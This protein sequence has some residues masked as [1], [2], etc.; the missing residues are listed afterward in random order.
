MLFDGCNMLIAP[1]R[2]AR[3]RN[4]CRPRWNDDVSLRMPIRHS[5]VNSL[6]IIRA[7]CYHRRDRSCDL[8]KKTHYFRYVA[9][10][11]LRQ[12]NGDDFMRVGI[13]AEMQFAPT[14]R[15]TNA[16][17]LIQPFAF[18][19]DLQ[20]STV[21]EEMERF[22]TVKRLWQNG[23][24]AP[25]AAQCR[26]VRNCNI[27]VEQS[28]DRSQQSFSLTQRLVE[29]Q[30]KRKRGL[31][32]YRRI[33]R[34]TAT[35]SRRRSVPCRDGLFGKPNRQLSPPHQ[36]CIIVWPVRHSVSRLGEFVTATLI[37]LVWHGFPNRSMERRGH[38][39]DRATVP[40][41]PSSVHL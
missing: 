11:V 32:G 33:D 4:R 14:P 20:A 30:A 28:R 17:L 13:D 7:V 8:F 31:D 23:Q 41:P 25:S 6:T 39:T 24:A 1:R 38:P 5:V 40:P 36:R 22:V 26:V 18:A 16:T 9:D 37:E 19:I 34:L 35:L 3:T 29:H 10:I 21:D 2:S 15:G 27:D 12:F